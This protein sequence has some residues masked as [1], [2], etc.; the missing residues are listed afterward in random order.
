MGID[1]NGTET[2]RSNYDYVQ[3]LNGGGLNPTGCPNL[4]LNGS[5]GI[6]V[7]LSSGSHPSD[8]QAIGMST[9]TYG[10]A[11]GGSPQGVNN[12]PIFNTTASS[13]N[14]ASGFVKGNGRAAFVRS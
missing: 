5:L 6:N 4:G 14:L 1:D 8:I 3:F 7:G 13:T 9:P 11:G 2:T 12:W 10:G